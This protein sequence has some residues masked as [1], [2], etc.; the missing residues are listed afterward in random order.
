MKDMSITFQHVTRKIRDYFRSQN[1]PQT[2][3]PLSRLCRSGRF[4]ICK[5]AGDR[6]LCARIGALGIYPGAQA[7][8]ICPHNGSQCILQLHGSRLCLDRT[9]SENILVSEY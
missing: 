7:E 1:S 5:V 8:L 3:V 2:L 6:K 9:I 4:T